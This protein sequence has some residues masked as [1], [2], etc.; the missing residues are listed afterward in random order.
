M[1]AISA[2]STNF[3]P[4]Q[5][6]ISDA[7]I[8]LGLGTILQCD[9]RS[10][11]LLFNLS[12]ATRTYSTATA[13]LTR[14]VF[15][16]GD[17]ISH[18]EG[19]Q[20]KVKSTQ[21]IDG[22]L[23]YLGL[24]EAGE[25]AELVETQLA[26][27]VSFQGPKD[28]LLTGQLDRNN[29]FLLRALSRE[30]LADLALN[31]LRGM[32]GPRVGLIPHQLYIAQEVG[33]RL[34]P[35][36]L[37][38]DEVGLGKTIQAGLILHQQL[39]TGRAQ[40]ALI[41]VPGSLCHQWLVELLR[42][43]GLAVTLVDADRVKATDAAFAD[44]GIALASINW[45]VDDEAGLQQALAEK[46][47]LV[48][49]DEAH[50]LRWSPEE[51]SPE[52][53]VVSQ[54]AVA[55]PGL[56]LLTA[57]PEQAGVNGFFAQLQLLDAARYPSLE[58]FIAEEEGYKHIA[59]AVSNLEA[60][61]PLAASDLAALQERLSDD[62]LALVEVINHA[63]TSTEQKEQAREQL[64]H[65]LL[66]R[67]GTGRV[68][69]RNRRASVAGFPERLVAPIPLENPPA[70]ASLLGSLAAPHQQLVA[71]AL[72]G[73]SWPYAALYPERIYAQQQTEDGKWWEFDPRVDW[74]LEQLE[75]L[76]G[77]KLLLICAHADTALELSEALRRRAGIL[78]AVFH[79]DMPL[80]ERDRAAAWFA[81][82][83]D[84]CPILIC[85]EIGSEGRNFQFAQHLILFDLPAHPDLLEQRI[86]RLDRIGQKDTIHIYVPYLTQSTQEAW[87]NWC[88]KGLDQFT[89]PRP[90]GAGLWDK[91]SSQLNE[92]LQQQLPAEEFL[93]EVIASRLEAEQELEAG[94]HRLLELASH[95]PEISASL[96]EQLS[97]A[98]GD[99]ALKEY[100]EI[101]LDVFRIG[102][103][104]LDA[105]SLFIKPGQEADTAIFSGVHFDMEDGSSGTFVRDQ[106]L[107]RDD[108]HFFSWEHPL[109]RNALDAAIS[110]TQGNTTVALLKNPALP[111]GT[112]L[113]EAF[114]CLENNQS[115]NALL[116]RYLPAKSLRLLL[117]GQGNDLSS[118]VSFKG[119][120]RQVMRLKKSL[121]RE[122]VKLRKEQLRNLLAKAEDI[123]EANLPTLIEQAQVTM[124]G[125]FDPEIARLK[126]LR[127]HNPSVRAS[128]IEDLEQLRTDLGI[129]L[130]SAKLR[131]DAVRVIVAG[132]QE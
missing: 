109:V 13:P 46:W 54:L 112:L 85:S 96:V 93:A 83:Q 73:Q 76:A 72:T 81:D 80:I 117:D 99:P 120:S 64:I 9:K 38:A 127:E 66:D 79:E 100:L 90:V 86:G 61:T 113:L 101:A 63:E 110:S 26:S 21:N 16:E 48:I 111:A 40:R 59:Q 65:Q 130:N 41:L 44:A 102:S 75:R 42:R 30:A 121:G 106:A 2:L 52:Y 95:R 29:E 94:R 67:Y 123:A 131:L 128:E 3:C 50:H 98:D 45:L 91:F 31:P 68:L 27:Q 25:E 7:E 103:E 89:Q 132:G 84:G 129:E 116:E 114:F 118:K 53:K 115:Q 105:N 77:E 78:A 5:R 104:D 20:L 36:V 12:G 1:P 10:L 28:R 122:V 62:S 19:W 15:G 87:F 47:D 6:W 57:T 43:F 71:S 88:H 108:L 22:L 18:A 4:G 60:G 11:T 124:L 23:V 119:I 97:A 14:V 35:R 55:S 24:N 125:L 56:L 70:Y 32:L 37:L 69:F 74:L 82:T 17:V 126:A 49:V 92:F 34:A 58:E 107:A 33:Q 51:A 39:V 8:E